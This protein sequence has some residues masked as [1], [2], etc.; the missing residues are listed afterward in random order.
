MMTTRSLRNFA[1]K[2]ALFLGVSVQAET[3]FH[4][5]PSGNDLSGDGSL[6]AP[7]KTI[8]GARDAIRSSGANSNMQEDIVVNLRGGRYEIVETIQFTPADSGSNGHSII[9]RSHP[10]ETASV[11]GGKRVTGWTQVPGKPYWMASVPISAGFADYFR[12]IYVNGVRAERARGK[13]ITGIDYYNDPD[14]P[15]A[16]DGITFNT[17][18]LKA[19]TKV[20]DL[21]LNHIASFKIDEFPVIALVDDAASGRTSVRLQQPYCQARFNRG[22]GFFE[23]TDQWMIVQAFEE[24]DEPGEWYLDRTTD[25]LFYYPNS[26]ENMTTAQVDA[27][28]VDT[29][30]RFTGTSTTNKVSNIRIQNLILEHGNWLYP[31]DYYIGGGQAEIIYGAA[32]PTSGTSVNF[33]IPGQVVLNNTSDI[34][35]IG[36]TIRHQGACG[37]QV[38]NGAR[39]TLI[40]GNRFFDLTGAAVIGGRFSQSAIPNMEKCD[41]T[42]VSNNVIRNTGSDFAGATLVNNLGHTAFQVVHNDMAD[43]P[44]MGFHQRTDAG[45]GSGNGGTV[46]SFN[47]IS[48]GNV[49]AR[50]GVGDGGFIYTFGVW[51]GSTVEGNDINTLHVSNG[52]LSGFYL[53]NAS[54]GLNVIRNVMRGV[55]PGNMG[56]KFVRSLNNDPTVNTANGNYGDSTVNWWQVVTDPNYNQL[57]LG[58]PLPAAAQAIVDFAGLEPAYASLCNQIYGGQDLARGKTATASSQWD[59]SMPASC[60]VDWDY[61]SK[62]HQAS[63]DSLPWWSVDLGSAHVIQRIEISART[64]LDQPDS[65][66]NF[67]VQASN[68]SGFAT[69]T[70]L[71]EQN[72]VPFPYRR[73]GLSNSWIRFVNNPNGFRFLRVAKVASG[74]LN[75]SEFQVFGYSAGFNHTGM[76]WD[77]SASGEKTDGGGNWFGPNQWWAEAGNQDWV[78]GG[79]A[80]FG[81][82][83]SPAGVISLDGA[84]ATVNSL[85]F[86]AASSGNHTISGGVLVLEG[87][88]RSITTGLGLNP[89][90]ASTITGTSGLVCGGLG[91]VTLAG[92]NT[93]TGGVTINGGTLVVGSAGALNGPSPNNVS[94]SAGTLALNGNHITIPNP[95]VTPGSVIRNGASSDATLTMNGGNMT[96]FQD[97]G[98][99]RLAVIMT[100]STSPGAS[101]TFTGGLWIK[102][103][104]IE[105]FANSSLGNG[106]VTL[107][108]SSGSASVTLSSHTSA[109][110]SFPIIVPSGSSG[111]LQINNYFNYSPNFNGAITLN[112]TLN[113]YNAANHASNVYRLSLNGKI[114]GIGGLYINSR[115]NLDRNQIHLAHNGNDFT[116]SVTINSGVVHVSGIANGGMPSGIGASTSDPGNLV[117]DGGTLKYTGGG[118]T[119]DRAF[120]INNGKTAAI[121]TAGDLSFSGAT[122]PATNGALHKAG[123]GALTLSGAQTH[124]GATTV[125]AGTLVFSG[126][127][128]AMTGGV[129]VNG[130]GTLQLQANPGNTTSGTSTALPALSGKLSVADGSVVQLRSDRD[131]TFAGGDDLGGVGNGTLTID[132]NRLEAGSTNK[133]I[134]FATEGMNIYNE[135]INVTGG[136]GYGLRLGGIYN[137]LNS[138]LNLNASSAALSID[139]VGAITPVAALTVG[140]AFDTEITGPISGAGTTLTKIDAGTLTLSGAN[141]FTGATTVNSGTLALFGGSHA[142]AITVNN[143]GTSLGFLLGSTAMSTCTVTFGTGTTVKVAGTP[144]LASYTLMTATC[145]QGI[146]P[147][148]DTPIAGYALSVTGGNTLVLAQTDGYASWASGK[149]LD[150]SNNGVSLDPDSN[151]ISNLLEYV[152][153]GDPLV[154]E[155]PSSILPDLDVSGANFVFTFTRREQS[156]NDTTQAFEYGSDLVGW[157]L[158]N[159]TSP[160]AGQVALGEPSGGLQTVTVTLPKS[161]AGPDGRLFGRL[162]V[163]RP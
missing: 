14:T 125:G 40:Q 92:G 158:L 75:F 64:D 7:W 48:L 81:S 78:H 8:A 95:S 90:I 153:N 25:Q 63:G 109:S 57:A 149:G 52:N 143:A 29:L 58:Q 123:A 127:N 121:E 88:S 60:A 96:G 110:W 55:K 3:A 142:S 83:K 131:V 114:G 20:G 30:M 91:A 154:S 70:V 59:P 148:L 147:A 98:T 49:G 2:L 119:S 104:F 11:S 6:A 19:Y 155:S 157:T 137:G 141:T 65:R 12:Q 74:G 113:L 37:I 152:L 16:I 26:F 68:D 89:V 160:T 101:N 44:Y 79:D 146:T 129:T 130:G 161:L 144:T 22:E 35:F 67:Q 36:N 159:I 128:S 139:Y 133:T 82:G 17:A 103:G 111:N 150:D 116:G 117:F 145:F 10:G 97:G 18:D 33:E 1:G 42:L 84:T 132:V 135:T 53:D 39:N 99:G 87:A 47:K 50:H 138:F 72:A 23:A 126:E 9:Y 51:P 4:V 108:D 156:G 24:L 136:H 106:T 112:R 15:Q 28:V 71:A 118:T 107:G 124:T 85:T 5:S 94:I 73:T 21:R 140:G 100:D 151:G 66:C 56:Y 54:Y 45:L 34:Q 115:Q 13:W 120:T 31:R 32:A 61:T 122:G 43:A 41:N 80:T 93:F 86:N 77:A 134:S 163:T 62:W 69:Y 76:L 27:P 162:S 102:K 105:L 46:V 38:Y